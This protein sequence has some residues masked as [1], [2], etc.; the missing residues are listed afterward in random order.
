MKRL[1]AVLI[2]AMAVAGCDV[3]AQTER[4]I[5]HDYSRIREVC[6]DGVIYLVYGEGSRGGI[7]PKINANHHPYT[8]N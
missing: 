3:Q 6:I 8:C 7:T 4:K 1:L 5:S 2:G